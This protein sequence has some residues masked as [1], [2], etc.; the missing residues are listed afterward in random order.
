MARIR[1]IKPEFWTA[2]QVMELS[3]DARLLFVGM[4]NFCDDAGV[5]PAALKTLKAEVFPGDDITS[6]DIQTMVDEIIAQGLLVEFE[7]EGRRWWH[8]TGWKHQLINRPT[9]SRY[10]KPP[11]NAPLPLAA[12]RDE[13]P[14]APVELTAPHGD[15]VPDS[16][17]L[18]DDSLRTHG[19]LTEDSLQEGKGRERKGV[20]QNLSAAPPKT[21]EIEPATAEVPGSAAPIPAGDDPS[22][23][24]GEL[25]PAEAIPRPS[26]NPPSSEQAACR[27]TWAAYSGAYLDRYGVEPVRNA[28]VN[29]AIKGF[30]R[31]IG[32]DESPDVARYYVGHADA[33]YARKCHDAGAMLAD[34]E[35]LR[36]EWATKRQVTGVTA[37]QQERSGTMRSAVERICAEREAA[38]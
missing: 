6:G 24:S 13:L 28:K 7:H 33:Y 2:E 8:V 14:D 9:P 26:P 36:T 35:K 25:L 1:T 3:R 18:T 31:R 17:L 20:N 10:P 21:D 22:P 11:R 38:A 15:F 34:A 4:W 30:T 27:A 19:G 29:A 37:R 5:H 16:D 23:I 32:A 12:G